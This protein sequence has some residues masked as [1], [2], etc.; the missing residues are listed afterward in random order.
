MRAGLQRPPGP[1]P[2]VRLEK[3]PSISRDLSRFRRAG[4]WLRIE[5]ITGAD[6]ASS[7]AWVRDESAI[8]E[9]GRRDGL[10]ALI[11]NM[12]PGSAAPTGS[13]AST[14]TSSS[15]SGLTTS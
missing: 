9:A 8:A 6:G 13:S 4:A 11:T 12:A 5:V 14:R 1:H 7:L 10:Y 15:P 3:R 2:L